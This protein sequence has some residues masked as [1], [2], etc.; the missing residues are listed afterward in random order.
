MPEPDGPAAPPVVSQVKETLLAV[1][2]GASQVTARPV[3][4][5]NIPLLTLTKLRRAGSQLKVKL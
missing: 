5:R 3:E 1:V 4:P 2:V